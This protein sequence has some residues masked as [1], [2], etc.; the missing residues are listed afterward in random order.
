MN[1]LQINQSDI[2]G[3]AAIASYRLHQGLLRQGIESRLLVGHAVLEDAAIATVP[4]HPK[5]ERQLQRITEKLGLHYL[6]L[7]ATGNI[8]QHPFYAAADVLNFHNLHNNYFNYLAIPKLVAHKPAVLALHDMWSFTGHCTYSY[9]CDRWQRGC[10]HC[11]YPETYPAIARDNTHLEWRLKQWSYHNANLTV[12]APSRWLADLARRS[13]LGKFPIHHIPYGIDTEIYQPLDPAE[14][15]NQLNLPLGKAVL[16]F[17]AE[18]L[19]DSRKGGDLLVAALAA[20]PASLKTEVV[21]LTLG[22]SDGLQTD[23][24]GISSLNL[25]YVRDDHQKAIAYSAADLFI[26]PTRADNLPLVLQES[27]ACGT[28]MVSF[29]IG[30]VPEIVRPGITGYLAQAEEAEDLKN[31]IVQLLENSELR[32]RM[33]QNCRTIALQEYS[34]THQSKRYADLYQQVLQNFVTR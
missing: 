34:L 12:V 10:G 9:D 22:N 27:L 14:C 11:P 1:V 2:S 17:V 32:D 15:R 4:R 20:L 18:S 16:L 21:L 31:G 33:K 3:G 6:N 24:L 30:G 7:T 28:P 26:F 13:L 8:A 19:Q 23:S 29:K 25:G 5:V